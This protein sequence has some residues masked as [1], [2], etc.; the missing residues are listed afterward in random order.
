MIDHILRLVPVDGMLQFREIVDA[1]SVI[2]EDLGI[3]LR[4]LLNV[5]VLVLRMAY[6][7]LSVL[8]DHSDC[9]V[10]DVAE[11]VASL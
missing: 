2:Y 9:V 10:E 3:F 11:A 6:H 8:E 4:W 1:V 7:M 5:P